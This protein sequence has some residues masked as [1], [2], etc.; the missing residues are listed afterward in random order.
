MQRGGLPGKMFL[1]EELEVVGI[2]HACCYLRKGCP[3][4]KNSQYKG[5]QAGT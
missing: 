5:D 4:R 3:S 1:S 2:T